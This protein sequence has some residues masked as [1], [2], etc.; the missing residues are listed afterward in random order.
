MCFHHVRGALFDVDG[1]EA[2]DG[3]RPVSVFGRSLSGLVACSGR[4]LYFALHS[5]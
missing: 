3:G 5:F 4:G 2:E 1:E